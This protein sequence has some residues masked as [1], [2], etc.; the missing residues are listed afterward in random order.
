MNFFFPSRNHITPDA[1]WNQNQGMGKPWQ[2]PP[3]SGR[4]PGI[5]VDAWGKPYDSPALQQPSSGWQQP[6]WPSAPGWPGPPGWP[7]SPGSWQP[8]PLPPNGAKPSKN[9]KY[10][11][12][13]SRSSGKSGKAGGGGGST[14][15]RQSGGKNTAGKSGKSGGGAEDDDYYDHTKDDR[16]WEILHP[17]HVVGWQ[18]PPPPPHGGWQAPPVWQQAPPPPV[19][20]NKWGGGGWDKPCTYMPTY[21]P[22]CKW[23]CFGLSLYKYILFYCWYCDI[24]C[25]H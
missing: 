7:G 1:S 4:A 16:G 9:W 21:V 14:T 3:E 20:C 6:G 12:V 22:T 18:P 25:V 19:K 11:E 24:I 23:C 10:N 2:P 8:P 17:P 15:K 13:A 5:I